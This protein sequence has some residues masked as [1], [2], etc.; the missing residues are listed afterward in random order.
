MVTATLGS[1]LLCAQY[2]SMRS[3]FVIS[4]NPS[5]QPYDMGIAAL[6]FSRGE[7]EKESAVVGIGLWLEGRGRQSQLSNTHTETLLR[8][9][10]HP[11][12]HQPRLLPFFLVSIMKHRV[13]PCQCS[14]HKQQQVT[15]SLVS[16]QASPLTV[17]GWGPG[18]RLQG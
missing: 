5:Q 17:E 11:S 6:S 9:H 3:T 2:H 8:A 1:Y 16:L 10:S 4:F 15:G 12:F 7:T 18:S 14:D 13:L